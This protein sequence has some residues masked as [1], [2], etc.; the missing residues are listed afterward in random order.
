MLKR[1][2]LLLDGDICIRHNVVGAANGHA[3]NNED[4]ATQNADHATWNNSQD[5]G[6]DE[7]A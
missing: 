2:I 1:I 7:H 5:A 3:G 6:F 4:A